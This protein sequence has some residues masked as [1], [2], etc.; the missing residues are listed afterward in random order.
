M[1]FVCRCAVKNI[2]THSDHMQMCVLLLVTLI[3]ELDL[4]IMKMYVKMNF[5]GQGFQKLEHKQAD[6]QTLTDAT[7]C[8]TN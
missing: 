8:T 1:A 2:L 4:D 6:R 7:E 5:L 3:C